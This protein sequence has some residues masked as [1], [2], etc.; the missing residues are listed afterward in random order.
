V[1]TDTALP[2]GLTPEM[3]EKFRTIGLR[4]DRAGKV[5]HQGDEVTHPR[6]RQAL[7]RWLD[8][9]PD[10][11]NIVRLDAQRYA[12]VE[13]DDAHLRV[14][15]ARWEGDRVWLVLD[16]GSDEELAYDTLEAASDG[17]AYCR[18]RAGLLRAR[19]TTPAYYVLAERM[20][21]S[22]GGVA[23]QAN[24]GTHAIRPIH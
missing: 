23:L 19:L 18:V 22:A 12:Y 8:V 7:L 3:I 9:T 17:T 4:I 14:T 5:W 24:G 20:V 11:R 10:G 16:D 1:S 21:E 2:P 15:S 13:V 6:L